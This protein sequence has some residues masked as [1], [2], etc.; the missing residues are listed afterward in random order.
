MNEFEKNAQN[1]S[2]KEK[3]ELP[4]HLKMRLGYLKLQK[5]KME[6][7]QE[8]QEQQEDN[9]APEVTPRELFGT[10]Y[11]KAMKQNEKDGLSD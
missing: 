1:M 7:Q 9:K 2:E 5:E 4:T 8:E 3:Q 10:A 6:Q 11:D